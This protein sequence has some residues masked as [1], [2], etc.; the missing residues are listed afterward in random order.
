MGWHLD[1]PAGTW[2][3]RE[4]LSITGDEGGGSQRTCPPRSFKTFS[5]SPF[6][7]HQASPLYWPH[8]N[9]SSF[10][11]AVLM[12][13]PLPSS[14]SCCNTQLNPTWSGL[15]Q[16]LV[17]PQSPQANSDPE[18]CDPVSKVTAAINLPEPYTLATRSK[19]DSGHWKT[20]PL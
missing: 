20:V 15:D 6:S 5:S 10:P 18:A 1:V 13:P 11:F 4:L 16:P 17:T 9:L 19:L 7:H 3:F 12:W 8:C 2:P 14:H